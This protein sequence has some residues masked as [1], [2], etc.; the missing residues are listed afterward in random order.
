M[1][2]LRNGS[3]LTYSEFMQ[4]CF[5]PGILSYYK[6]IQ[7]FSDQEMK[8]EY[9]IWTS[10]VHQT[11]PDAYHTIKETLLDF[12]EKNGIIVVS[13]HNTETYIRRDYQ[14]LFGFLPDLIFAADNDEQFVKPQTGGITRLLNTYH[15][16]PSE[17]LMVDD[18]MPGFEMAQQCQIP[19]AAAGYSMVNHDARR[20]FR[21]HADYYLDQPEQLNELLKQS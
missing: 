21:Q 7:H 2:T 1:K 16:K 10:H 13:S 9:A 3:D 12:R 14:E 8:Q 5:D 17:C 6:Q 18:L 20:F 19:F 11:V 4:L 15:L